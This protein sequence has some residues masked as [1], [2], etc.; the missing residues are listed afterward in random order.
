PYHIATLHGSVHGNTTHDPYAPFSL[1]NLQTK[2]FDYWALGHIHER[3]ELA[4]TPPIIYPGNTQRRHRNEQGEKGCYIVEM[5]PTNTLYNFI[6]LQSM[7]FI[8]HHLDV[9]HSKTIHDLEQFILSNM[10]KTNE[11]QLIHL[12]LA[13]TSTELQTFQ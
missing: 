7:Q 11:K 6:P 10:I 12:T 5:T 8:E 13:S 3:A 2:P 9:T 1:P 4:T